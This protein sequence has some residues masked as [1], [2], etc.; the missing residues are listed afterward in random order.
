M[1]NVVDLP[2]GQ[3]KQLQHDV[4]DID[5]AARLRH[6]LV[7]R[8]EIEERALKAQFLEWMNRQGLTIWKTGVLGHE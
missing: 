8:T 5:F 4:T 3:R 7:T 2:I 6:G 1:K